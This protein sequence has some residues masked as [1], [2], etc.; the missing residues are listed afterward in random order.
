M[1]IDTTVGRCRHCGAVS[2][3]GDQGV[4]REDG[5]PDGEAYWL[6]ST[7]YVQEM[8]RQRHL[9]S[10]LAN[11]TTDLAWAMWKRVTGWTRMQRLLE[12]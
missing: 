6:C 9:T 12:G 1:A 2:G 4:I 5:R 3:D 8:D 7:D 11:N 10:S